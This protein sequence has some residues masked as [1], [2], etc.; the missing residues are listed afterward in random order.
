M[1]SA[2]VQRWLPV[3]AMTMATAA[4][5]LSLAL[6]D[7]ASSQG[8][9]ITTSRERM[10][11]VF[12]RANNEQRKALRVLIV[13]G[14]KQSRVFEPIY[15]EYGAPSF[16]QRLEQAQV[17]AATLSALDCTALLREVRSPIP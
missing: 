5:V 15:R 8:R 17:G 11:A 13:R 2:K 12:C 14:A 3:V 7:K 6:F 1:I 10:T 16:R 4:L 9:E